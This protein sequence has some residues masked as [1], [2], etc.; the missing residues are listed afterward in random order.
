M[1]SDKLTIL[2]V[3]KGRHKFTDRWLSFANNFLSNYKIIIADGSEEN[4]K[5]I[6]DKKKYKNLEIKLPNFPYDENIEFFINKIRNSLKLIDTEYVLYC[7]NDDF[8]FPDE[9]KNV[10]IFLQDNKD[11]VAG[12]GEIFNFSISSID[13]IYGKIIEFKR[14]NE[15]LPLNED[16]VFERLN[17]YSKNRHGLF[18]NI[19]KKTALEKMLDGAIKNKFFDLVIFQ[20][21]WNFFLPLTGKI[22]CSKNLYMLHQD[23]F[24]MISKNSNVMSFEKSFFYEESVFNN[25]FLKLADEIKNEHNIEIDKAK[26]KI[27]SFFSYN[28]LLK[29]ISRNNEK[30]S[31]FKKLIINRMRDHKLSNF[32]LNYKKRFAI[33]NNVLFSKKIKLIQ[34]FL[35]K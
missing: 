7:E 31:S 8:M 11:Y 24:N 32:M 22:Y 28:E 26:S 21:Y 14:F 18:H 20:Y 9:I 16:D 19:T 3:L 25:F 4:K 10:L 34:D 35:T 29:L 15:Y 1:K 30:N 23:H 17:S 13:E 5:Y 12:R 33:N 6:L 27:L 2:L